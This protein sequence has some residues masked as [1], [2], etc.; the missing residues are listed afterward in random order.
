MSLPEAIRTYDGEVSKV[1]DGDTIEVEFKF[2]CRVRVKDLW[3]AET[4]EQRDH[5]SEKQAGLRAKEALTQLFA[6]GV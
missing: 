4:R 2:N 6:T 1:I 5:P 3:C